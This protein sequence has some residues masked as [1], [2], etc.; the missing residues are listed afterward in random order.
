MK[1]TTLGSKI[2]YIALD[3]QYA[4]LKEELLHVIDHVYSSG[5]ML[6][7]EFTV[8]F[9][10]AIAETTDRKFAIAVNSCSTALLIC[11]LYYGKL[12]PKKNVVVPALSFV[13]TGN[14]PKLANW[15]TLFAD[16]DIN[17]LLDLSKIDIHRNNIDVISYVNLYGNVLDYDKLRLV[18][19]F[20]HE[21]TVIIE[22][23]AQSFGALYKGKPSGKLGDASCLSFDP[24]KNLPNYGSGGMILTDDANLY[25]FALNTRDNGKNNTHRMIGTNTKMSE[26]DCAQ[27]M[28]KMKYF[29]EWQKRRTTIAQYYTDELLDYVDCPIPNEGVVHAWHKYVIRTPKRTELI[30]YL[31]DHNIES[32]VHYHTPLPSL[33]AFLNTPGLFPKADRLAQ[34]SLGLPIYPELTD[35]EVERIVKSIQAAIR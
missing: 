28:V 5:Q 16:V 26:V 4:T 14:A 15:N 8:K 12:F 30:N 10:D 11:F 2:R 24:T 7:G 13:A 22:D 33:H 17:G 31:I 1:I 27:M 18:A 3:R 19:N 20:F 23:A 21:N 9:E 34:R 35:E 32:K 6:D 29:S 25:T